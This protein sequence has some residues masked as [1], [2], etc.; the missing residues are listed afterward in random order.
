MSILIFII[1]LIISVIIVSVVCGTYYG[2]EA[3]KC[4]IYTANGDK[5]CKYGVAYDGSCNKGKCDHDYN[6]TFHGKCC[7][8]GVAIDSKYCN[9]SPQCKGIGHQA[10]SNQGKCCKYGHKRSGIDCYES[11]CTTDTNQLIARTLTNGNCTCYHGKAKNGKTKND[12][13]CNQICTSKGHVLHS[14]ISYNGKCCKQYGLA[15]GVKMITDNGKSTLVQYCNQPCTNINNLTKGGKCCKYGKIVFNDANGDRYTKCKEGDP[16]GL[17]TCKTHNKNT[18]GCYNSRGAFCKYGVAAN[19]AYCNQGGNNACINGKGT[20][21]SV[22]TCCNKVPAITQNG[23]A[24]TSY[25][26]LAYM[27]KHCNNANCKTQSLTRSGKCCN[28]KGVHGGW[29]QNAKEY[30]IYACKTDLEA[31]AIGNTRTV[32]TDNGK[33]VQSCCEYGA[34]HYKTKCN[35]KCDAPGV[36]TQKG[37]KCCPN[38]LTKSK[39]VCNISCPNPKQLTSKN[40]YAPVNTA[41]GGCCPN[42]VAAVSTKRYKNNVKGIKCNESGDFKIFTYLG[43]GCKYGL[44][45]DGDGNLNKHA[46]KQKCTNPYMS[47]NTSHGGC[48]YCKFGVT[49]AYYRSVKRTDAGGTLTLPAD[50]GNGCFEKKNKNDKNAVYVPNCKGTVTAVPLTFSGKTATAIASAYNLLSDKKLAYKGRACM[51]KCSPFWNTVKGSCTREAVYNRTKNGK[52]CARGVALCG[53]SAKRCYDT[54]KKGGWSYFRE[55]VDMFKIVGGLAEMAVGDEE[56]VVQVITG[57]Y[58]LYELNKNGLSRNSHEPHTATGAGN[59]HYTSIMNPN[60]TGFGYHCAANYATRQCKKCYKNR[61]VCE[62][63]NKNGKFC[64]YSAFG[65]CIRTAATAKHYCLAGGYFPSRNGTTNIGIKTPLCSNPATQYTTYSKIAVLDADG[66]IV[67]YNQGNK[68]CVVCPYGVG[69]K[70]GL[71][72]CNQYCGCAAN[73]GEGG[74][75]KGVQPGKKKTG[76]CCA[77]VNS[78][79]CGASGSICK[80]ITSGGITKTCAYGTINCNNCYT[81]ISKC[82]L[83]N[84]SHFCGNTEAGGCVPVTDRGLGCSAIPGQ[85][86]YPSMSFRYTQAGG[87]G[88][89]YGI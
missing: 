2:I 73:T 84:N 88:T 61:S 31:C 27:H 23:A 59:V 51:H 36:L 54:T 6:R 74:C 14:K 53:T 25:K 66:A 24:I 80:K 50:N 16:A 60:N 29:S 49:K 86:Y 40:P 71:P 76:G 10:R 67:G 34:N 33:Y 85:K 38:G 78:A 62:G 8:Y 79:V 19:T 3:Q 56:G 46:C 58:G 13:G 4:T 89:E 20:Y 87:D 30:I 64:G 28:G 47:H 55:G 77:N 75:P 37:T 26:G 70:Y 48:Q 81:P 82:I 42:G 68:K 52:T 63:Y 21:N 9:T 44:A 18:G 57:A 35:V 45:E 65:A 22:G 5:C 83:T 41:A 11:F 15:N 7:T 1:I 17:Y 43:Q 12:G 69:E 32:Q 39:L 72:V